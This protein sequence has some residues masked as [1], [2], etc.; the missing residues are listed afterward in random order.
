MDV[1]V[2]GAILK[3]CLDL[4]EVVFQTSRDRM[5]HDPEWRFQWVLQGMGNLLWQMDNPADGRVQPVLIESD[6]NF[7]C[8]DMD[9]FVLKVMDMEGAPAFRPENGFAN[10]KRS[11]G[12]FAH[13]FVSNAK[14]L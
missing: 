14:Q 1:G 2:E 7:P 6:L 13:Q 12:L 4:I 3:G 9:D 11:P 10:V 5:D 8:Q